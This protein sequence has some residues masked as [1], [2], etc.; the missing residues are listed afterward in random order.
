MN[1]ATE[2]FDVVVV[3]AGQAGSELASSL[4]QQGFAG[5]IALLGDEPWLP[6]RRPPLSKGFL[7]GA[8]T[9]ES[10]FIRAQA[11]YDKQD[12]HCRTGIGVE[13]IDR[14]A[15]RLRLFD[16]SMIEYGKLALATGGRPRRLALQGADHANVHC[17][18]SIA[19][20]VHLQ[21]HFLPGK[22]LVVIGGG[23]I[24]LEAAAVG[25]KMGLDVTVVETAPR[26][27][28]RVTAPEISAFYERVHRNH[29]AK[30]LTGVGVHSLDGDTQ[31]EAVTLVDGT[32]L[33]A[34]V[35]IVGIGLIPNTELA[36][37]AGIAVENGI[38]VDAQTRTSDPDIVAAGDCTFHD[39]VFYGRRMRLESVSNAVDQ[40]RIAAATLAGKQVA[41][42]AVPWF[43]SDQYDLKLQMVGLSQGYDQLVVRG[44]IDGESFC[45]YYLKDGVVISADAVNRAPDFI[46]AKRLV[47]GRVVVAPEQLADEGFDLKT[48]FAPKSTVAA[49]EGHAGA[50]VQ[51]HAST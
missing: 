20:I 8:D 50:A 29:G 40:A 49:S 19:D 51:G 16:G 5:S 15:K 24:G 28:A 48:L 17:I 38:V 21:A 13:S 10:L 6:Y 47:A 34:D 25:I 12:I 44:N 27:L 4:R 37:V 22:K 11:F 9:Q 31:V 41:Y 26:V 23:Y 45:A 33:P 3:G 43:W 18:R 46:L 30:L 32:R 42:D 2:Q 35:V 36:E 1:A 7:S 39:N 14:A